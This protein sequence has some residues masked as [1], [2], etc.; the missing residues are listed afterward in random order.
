M[1]EVTAANAA[2]LYLGATL[3]VLFGLW[4]LYH[5]RTLRRIIL[6]SP[7]EL[8]VCEYCHFAYMAEATLKVTRCPQC[9]SF[10]KNNRYKG[11]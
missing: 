1:I 9:R 6:S 7:E 4:A 10:N 11:R 5:Y 8:L 2:L 3:A